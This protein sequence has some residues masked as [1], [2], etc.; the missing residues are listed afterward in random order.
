MGS[1]LRR[2]LIKEFSSTGVPIFQFGTYGS[3]NGSHGPYDLHVDP[4]GNVWVVDWWNNRIEEFNGSGAYLLQFGS[5][6]SGD[7]QFS[8]SKI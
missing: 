7:G 4:S 6:G 3:G 2:N 8:W 5:E 1:G